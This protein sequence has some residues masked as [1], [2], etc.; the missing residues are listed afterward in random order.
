MNYVI[1]NNREVFED[2]INLK[3]FKEVDLHGEER[4]D[5]AFGVVTKKILGDDDNELGGGVTMVPYPWI[6][7]NAG[8]FVLLKIDRSVLLDEDP[9]SIETLLKFF[10]P[11]SFYITIRGFN[12]EESYNQIDQ[13][14]IGYRKHLGFIE[15]FCAQQTVK[16]P[17]N[18]ILKEIEEKIL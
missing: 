13:F 10:D 17:L 8:I 2:K 9:K 3:N 12:R 4:V 15:D 14:L 11:K 6:L 7:G 16:D 5:G 18:Y 1:L